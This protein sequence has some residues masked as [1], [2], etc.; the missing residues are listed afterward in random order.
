MRLRER[1]Y[2]HCLDNDCQEKSLI[3]RNVYVHNTV[4]AICVELMKSKAQ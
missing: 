2:S 1:Y 3:I 4:R